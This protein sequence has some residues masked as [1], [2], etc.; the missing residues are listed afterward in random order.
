VTKDYRITDS[1]RYKNLRFLLTIVCYLSPALIFVF[2]WFPVIDH[3]YVPNSVITD[4]TVNAARHRPNDSVLDEIEVFF[5]LLKLIDS[6]QLIAAAEMALQ[7]EIAIPGYPSKGFRLP[8]DI[9]NIDKGPKLGAELRWV[10]SIRD[11]GKFLN[12]RASRKLT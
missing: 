2:I 4:E 10:V 11:M 1:A 3:Y 9:D 7:G 6:K 12:L 8:F 5:D